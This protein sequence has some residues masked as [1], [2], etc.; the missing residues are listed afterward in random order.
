[1]RLIPLIML[2]IWITGCEQSVE[3]I[4]QPKKS[5]ETSK[6]IVIPEGMVYVE[7]GSY[8]MGSSEEYA[9]NDEGPEVRIKVDGFYMDSTE[10]TNAEYAKFVEE[11]GYVT[12]AEREVD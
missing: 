8:V 6:A 11:T 12:V 4:E 2:S 1:M 7:G 9:E 10:V 5:L 3:K